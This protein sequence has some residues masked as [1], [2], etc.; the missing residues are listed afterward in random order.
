MF[1]SIGLTTCTFFLTQQDPKIPFLK[2][3]VKFTF[4]Y[5]KFVFFLCESLTRKYILQK[6]KISEKHLN[7]QD[8][9]YFDLKKN[10]MIIIKKK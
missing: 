7:Y 6:K 1:I 3:P 10:L 2:T 4:N 8:F 9:K 5:V